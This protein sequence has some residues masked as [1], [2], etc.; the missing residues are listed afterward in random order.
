MATRA[1]PLLLLLLACGPG[2][3]SA[4]RSASDD[5]YQ[6]CVDH[7]NALRAGIGL[8]PLAR[9]TDNER[10]ADGQALSDSESGVFHG[11]FR[12]CPGSAQN[13]CPGWGALTGAGGIVP[14]CLDAMWA[15]GPGGGHYDNMTRSSY[16]KVSC[17]FHSAGARDVWAVQDFQ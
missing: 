11:A 8:G 10:C 3:A 7:I 16:T 2:P 1:F 14:S 12:S 9:W 4:P 15:E 13:E 5:V 17:G 6:A